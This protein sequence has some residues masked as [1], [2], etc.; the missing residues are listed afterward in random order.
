MKYT[1][2]V[3]TLRSERDRLRD[4]LRGV[5]TALRAL[6]PNAEMEAGFA[7]GYSGLTQE[8]R[9]L[10]VLSEVPGHAM[11]PK[12]LADLIGAKNTSV[13]QLLYMLKHAGKVQWEKSRG[14]W[15]ESPRL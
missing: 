14:Y 2:I 12:Q 4:E 13:G 11:Q 6:E 7:N 5:E 1:K 8:E 10:Q 3:E 15:V 9:I